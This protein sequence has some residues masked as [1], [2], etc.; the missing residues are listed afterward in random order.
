VVAIS[1]LIAGA[2]Q[3]YGVGIACAV[4]VVVV[5]AVALAVI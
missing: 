5:F 4:V 3:R 2:T 1:A